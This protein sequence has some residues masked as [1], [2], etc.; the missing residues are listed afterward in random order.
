MLVVDNHWVAV[1]GWWICDSLYSKS[2]P[3]RIRPTGPHRRTRVEYVY[4]V[5][6]VNQNR[7]VHGVRVGDG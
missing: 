2:V 5:V 6:M 1:R 7:V 3:I 4:G